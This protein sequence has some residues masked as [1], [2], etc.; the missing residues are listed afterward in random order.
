MVG[1]GMLMLAMSAGL[2]VGVAIAVTVVSISISERKHDFVNFRALGVSN[3]EIFR[4]VLLE[5]V[6]TSILGIFIGFFT[7]T[8]MGNFIFAWAA[9][10]GVVLI[11]EI[12]P[13]STGLSILNI[14]LA[15]TLAV[16][17]SLRALF[18]TSISEETV[19]RII[20]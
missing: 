17:L 9:E 15:I 19:S 5:L 18:R 4:T 10:F 12:N 20:G 16:Y 1:Y 2:I 14:L 3:Q 6:I 7:G 13:M 8:A 11:M